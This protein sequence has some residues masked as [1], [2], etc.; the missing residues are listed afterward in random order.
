LYNLFGSIIDKK[1]RK[2]S[3]HWIY[4]KFQKEFG[5]KN[6]LVVSIFVVVQI[7]VVVILIDKTWKNIHMAKMKWTSLMLSKANQNQKTKSCY[8][9]SRCYYGSAFTNDKIISLPKKM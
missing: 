8:L 6:N 2:H 7:G 4:K 9:F 3:K 5:K 1:I